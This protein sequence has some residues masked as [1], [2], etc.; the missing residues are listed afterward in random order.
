[1]ITAMEM[2]S[3]KGGQVFSVA[4]DAT[5][6][7]A[8]KI[9]NQ[10]N[11]GAILIKEGEQIVGIWTERDLL[12]NTMEDTFDPKTAKIADYMVTELKY[13][14]HDETLY[15]LQDKFLGMRL[16]HM[17]IKRDGE[18]VGL[19]SAG[20]VMKSILNQKQKELRDLNAMVGWE[21]YD[22]WRW[23]KKKYS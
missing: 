17:L 3:A 22:N 4:R 15:Q 2:L 23:D 1:M 10:N 16:R 7:D 5:V 6:F 11:I 18:F 12:K 9:M 14:G 13:A 8:V 21:Y 20:D 19:L